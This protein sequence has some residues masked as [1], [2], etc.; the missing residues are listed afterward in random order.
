MISL[1]L[2]DKLQSSEWAELERFIAFK[3]PRL[4]SDVFKLL[5][6]LKNKNNSELSRKQIHGLL[7]SNEQFNDKRIRYLLT[8]FNKAVFAFFS[9][10]Q[11]SKNENDSNVLLLRELAERNCTRSFEKTYN[12]EQRRLES[13]N[14]VDSEALYHQYSLA[15]IKAKHDLGQ[16]Q[17]SSDVFEESSQ[18]LDNYFVAKKLQISAEKINLNFILKK[19]WTDPFLRNILQQIDEGL[20]QKSPY[21][22][23]Y[24]LIITSL[25]EPE[26]EAVFSLL[27]ERLQSLTER[28]SA[29][30]MTDLYQYLLNYCIRRINSGRLI[31]QDELLHVYQMAL[32]DGALLAEGRISQWD[33]K[34]IVTIALRTR[35][36]AFARGFIIDYE[37]KL[38][39]D[40]RINALAYNLANVNFAEGDY[41]ATIKQLAKVDLEDVFYRLDARS[42]LLKS[43]YELDDTDAL[44]Y[45]ATAFRN[46]L[47]RNR[48]I[49]DHQRKLYLNL[50]KHTL[51]LAKAGGQKAKIA[52]IEKRVSKNPNVAD[53][54]WIEEKI[55]E[56]KA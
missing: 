51:S 44:F 46:M 24:R 11:L 14:K 10:K 45:H 6:A 34:N 15:S 29:E 25:T 38:P 26:N 53:L 28:L 33:F 47:N 35:K 54:R 5:K 56:Q 36:L 23:L 13:Q 4:R 37:N 42:I 3:F 8:D 50:I 17:R 9:Y 48:K 21:I 20:F 22:Q 12:Q 30:E 49:S 2:V 55:S 1:E 40:Q 19:E 7:Y 39:P 16:G 31:F 32:Q 52:L 27:K 18:Y 43:Y 41:R